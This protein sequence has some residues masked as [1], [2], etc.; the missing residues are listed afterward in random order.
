MCVLLTALLTRNWHCRFLTRGAQLEGLFSDELW[1][2]HLPRKH[3]PFR[4]TSLS[5][6]LISSS[7]VHQAPSFA[8]SFAYAKRTVYGAR[9]SSSM[10]R[11]T[12]ASNNIQ[13]P[14]PVRSF[15]SRP[16]LTCLLLCQIT[17]TG[18][19][20]PTQDNDIADDL[21]PIHFASGSRRRLYVSLTP[22][23]DV[24]CVPVAVLPP[25]RDIVGVSLI[26]SI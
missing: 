8:V 9:E 19:E 7:S 14:L 15:R 2:C 17:A 4:G 21:G 11:R 24:A 20:D 18:F 25:P 22:I 3:Q 10:P 23:L 26:T 1:S 6:C 16:F 13:L 5:L 12:S